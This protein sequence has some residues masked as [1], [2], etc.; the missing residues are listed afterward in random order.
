MCE[1]SASVEVLHAMLIAS[2]SRLLPRSLLNASRIFAVMSPE[3]WPKDEAPSTAPRTAAET[4]CD[5]DCCTSCM[6]YHHHM[7]T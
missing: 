4:S 6:Q 1:Q 2:V 3:P 7:T 5:V